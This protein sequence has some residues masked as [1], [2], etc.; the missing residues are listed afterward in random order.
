MKELIEKILN[1]ISNLPDPA[2][3][4]RVVE[5]IQESD[6]TLGFDEAKKLLLSDFL[7]NW[8]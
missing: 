5:K 3:L 7:R 6:N 2:N 8:P 1:I 4:T